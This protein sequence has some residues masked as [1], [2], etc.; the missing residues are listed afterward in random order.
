MLGSTRLGSLADESGFGLVETLVAAIT[1]VIV[2]GALSLILVVSLHQAGRISDTVE[3]SQLGRTTMTQIVDELHSACLAPK[4]KPVFEKSKGSELVFVTAYGKEAQL[5]EAQK[6]KIVWSGEGGTLVD[7]SVPSTGTWPSFT[8]AAFPAKGTIIGKNISRAKALVGGVLEPV[9]IF[10]YYA[11]G[12][13]ATSSST[14][15]LS[16]LEALRKT[17]SETETIPLTAI[18]AETT[19]AVLVSFK[20]APSDNNTQL[21]RSSEFSNQVNFSFS[22]P[23]ASTNVDVESPCE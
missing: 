12:T 15:G 13:E 19:S 2:A 6:H 20:E 5:A 22:I 1:G 23:A 9:P 4:F 21:A 17:P 8:F 18:E 16:T 10:Q 3:A 7:Y 11:Y 14:T